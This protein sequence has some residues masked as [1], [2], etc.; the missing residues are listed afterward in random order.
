MI[1]ER[2][3]GLPFIL[4][5]V[6][7]S[8]KVKVIDQLRY[9]PCALLLLLKYVF[10]WTRQHQSFPGALCIACL[11]SADFIRASLVPSE[12]R[13]PVCSD[14]T[15]EYCA[16]RKKRTIMVDRFFTLC[17]LRLFLRYVHGSCC[18]SNRTKAWY[19]LRW[20]GWV[21]DAID[22]RLVSLYEPMS[23]LLGFLSSCW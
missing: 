4:H 17:W 3:I 2:F 13:L 12:P 23:P 6:P 15:S 10:L 5:V 14:W 22:L 7:G 1:H 20:R 11:T 18:K 21:S 16:Q 19:C 9:P 8:I